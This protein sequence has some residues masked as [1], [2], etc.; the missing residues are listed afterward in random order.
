MLAGYYTIQSQM[1]VPIGISAYTVRQAPKV[2]DSCSR[3]VTSMSIILE[4][5]FVS[6]WREL[7][8]DQPYI[9]S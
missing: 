6:K 3:L 9:L 5:G 2:L 7:V 1:V 8:L 4:W